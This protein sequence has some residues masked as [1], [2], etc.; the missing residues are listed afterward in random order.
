MRQLKAFEAY[1]DDF[2][3]IA[4]YLSKQ[5]YEGVSRIFYLEDEKGEL[6][7]LTIQTVESTSRN[8]NKY[9]CKLNHEIELGKPYHVIHEFARKTVLKM[10]YIVKQ[11]TFDEKFAYLENDLG[12]NYS[13]EQTTFKLW[14]P[15]AVYVNIAIHGQSYHMTRND[16]GVYSITL[17]GDY[18]NLK[19]TYYVYIDGEWKTCL[20]PYGKSSLA[21]SK[22]SVVI[23]VNKIKDEKPLLPPVKHYTDAIIYEMS[24]RDFTAQNLKEDFKYSKQYLGV[25]EENENTISKNIGFTYLKKLGVTHVQL[26][27]VLDI[28]SINENH[29]N[30][31]YNWGYDP[32]QFMTFEGSYSTDPNN[33]LA[34]IL[35]FKEMV[36]KIHEAGMRV[37][38]DVVFNHVF[39]LDDMCLQKVVPNY[40]FQMNRKGYYSNGS[41]CGNDY[42]SRRKMARKYIIDCC[43]YLMEVFHIDGFRFDLMGIIDVE[44][45]NELYEECHKIDPNVMIYGEGWNM[46]SFL[47]TE[48]RASIMNHS[49]I[50]NIAHFSDRFRD[51]VKGKTNKEE[52]YSKGYCTGDIN[53]LKYMKDVLSASVCND[54]LTNYFDEPVQTINYVECHDNQTCWDKLKECC[55]EDTREK[56]IMRQKMCIAAVMF[57]QGVPFIHSGQE[58]ARTK[59]GKHNTYN[60]KDDVNWINWERKDTFETIVD[61]TKDC[62]AIRKEYACLRYHTKELI[63]KH[64]SFSDIDRACLLYDIK[65]ENEHLTIIFNPTEISY[66]MATL[67][68]ECI[69]INGIVENNVVEGKMTIEPLSVIILGKEV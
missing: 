56:R 58:F 30:I 69:F 18:E 17:H 11:E 45:M 20:D 13:K 35:E 64:V 31:F 1:L 29:P 21:D 7:E 32:A 39:E 33:P 55:K 68:R 65:D 26:M 62:I 2:N 60:A 10:G 14:A 23:D 43:K 24:V 3:T 50:P 51:V 53:Q 37:T 44:T 49:K 59:Y 9:T 5:S 48:L 12:A 40:F 66:S 57:A 52:V 47:D 38:M 46:P 15:T 41:W 16:K 61:Y 63:K 36:H 67:R 34:R 54:Y 22:W 27:P 4:I 28:A 19:Y 6:E 8:Y 25:V 42:D